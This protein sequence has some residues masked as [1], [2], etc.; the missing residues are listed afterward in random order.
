MGCTKNDFK[1]FSNQNY[2]H[3]IKKKFNIFV[4]WM[5]F[6]KTRWSCP[7][8]SDKTIHKILPRGGRGQGGRGSSSSGGQGV[9][10]V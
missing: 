6:D 8:K 1:Y 5:E 3:F 2:P 9:V 4:F 10:K 7:W